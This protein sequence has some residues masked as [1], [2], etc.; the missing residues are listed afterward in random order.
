MMQCFKQWWVH[1]SFSHGMLVMLL[2][3][4]MLGGALLIVSDLGRR[5]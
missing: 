4:F 2:A 1:L 3:C 5:P